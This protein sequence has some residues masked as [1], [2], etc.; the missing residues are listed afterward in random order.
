MRIF[1]RLQRPGDKPGGPVHGVALCLVPLML[2]AVLT[3]AGC[4]GPKGPA[5]R[6]VTPET[7]PGIAAGFVPPSTLPDSLALLP[8]PP[9]PGSAAFA[10][11]EETYRLTRAFR[12]TPR[13]ALAAKDGDLS[14]PEVMETFSC[15]LDTRVTEQSAPHLYRLMRRTRTDAAISR[16]KAKGHYRRVRPF[17][18]YKEA[19][20]TPRDEAR[21][22]QSGSYPSGHSTIGW[23]WTL[24]LAEIAPDRTDAILTRGYAFGQSR[25]ICGVHWQSDV[26][27]GRTLASGVVARLHGDATF[28][29]E[30]LAAADEV[31]AARAEG[32]K[33]ARDCKAEEAVLA[34]P[35]PPGTGTSP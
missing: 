14:F 6:V 18:V 3:L 24:I 13:W 34:G 27:A 22:R 12:N 28:R 2:A 32:I 5:S 16:Q 30:L 21:L 15:A 29:A 23:T 33:P 26:E 11:D 7:S 9:P 10:A 35:L 4:A 8:P 31:A 19:S 1:N 17:V 25:V 20:C